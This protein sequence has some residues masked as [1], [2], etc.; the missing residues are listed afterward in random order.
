MRLRHCLP[1]TALALVLAAVAAPAGA[2]EATPPA[3]IAA[4]VAD[5]SRPEADR[6]RDA[7]RKPAEVIAFAGLKAGDTAIDLLPGGG[8]FTRLFSKVVGDK[9]LVYAVA[10]GL[11]P[12]APAGA[13]DPQAAVKAIAAEAG[14]ANVRVVTLDTAATPPTPAEMAW[15]SLNYHDLQNRPNADLGAFNRMVLASLKPGGVYIVIDHSAQ[16]GSGKRDTSTLH[17]IDKQF[18]KAEVMAAGF[19][20]EAESNALA[21]P[22]DDRTQVVRETG[23]RG[24]T[25]QFVLKFR[26][27]R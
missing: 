12:N 25:D 1:A 21:N 4:A 24:K 22:Q 6:A 3:A 13:R 17:R 20:F 19:V 7:D 26:K 23:V 9:G 2:A 10:N 27:P 11:P 14:H 5:A 8:Y 15:T 16:D 18:V